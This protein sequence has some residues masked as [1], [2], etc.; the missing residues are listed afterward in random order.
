M[1]G[2]SA[3]L[4]YPYHVELS[5]LGIQILHCSHSVM[6]GDAERIARAQKVQDDMISWSVSAGQA[7]GSAS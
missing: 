7:T 1:A 3:E 4:I 6:I 5:T 2:S